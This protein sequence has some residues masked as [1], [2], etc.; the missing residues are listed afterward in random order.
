MDRSVADFNV[1]LRTIRIRDL[2]I[3]ILIAGI[4]TGSLLLIFPVDDESG[5]IFLTIFLFIGV[6]LFS[7]ALMGTTGLEKNLKNLFES[8]TRNEIIYI[9]I[10]NLLFAFLF[11]FLVSFLDI[12]IGFTDP[13]WISIW[14]IDSIDAESGIIILDSII[15][16]IFAPLLEELVF[17]GILFN[18]LKIRTGIIPAIIISSFIFGIGHEFGG[19]TSAFIFGICM[20]ILYLKTDNI[21]VPISVHFLNNVLATIINITGID[22][23]LAQLPWIVP[24]LAITLIGTFYLIKYVLFRIFLLLKDRSIYLLVK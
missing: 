7:Y 16:I 23:I 20:C 8:D 9:L 22:I 1:R 13:T 3:G 19:M 17:R 6:L 12:I 4:I 21:L 15:T 5:D 14:D 2:I 18:R 11:T 24:S 10:I